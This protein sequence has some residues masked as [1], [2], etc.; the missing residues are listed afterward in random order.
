[1][2]LLDGLS[3]YLASTDPLHPVLLE[4][5]RV[6]PGIWWMAEATG[7]G[8]RPLTPRAETALRG[9]LAAAGIVLVDKA[10][11][12]ALVALASHAEDL[13]GDFDEM[14]AALGDDWS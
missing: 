2:R 9:K 4:L 14:L 10:P 11:A 1:M 13:T 6:A 7:I 5:R 8:S 12:D 3:V